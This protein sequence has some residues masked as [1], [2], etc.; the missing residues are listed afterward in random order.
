M[1]DDT[2]HH[3]GHA[4][5][6]PARRKAGASSH[7]ATAGAKKASTGKKGATRKSAAHKGGAGEA[8]TT[9]TKTVKRTAEH[10]AT[11]AKKAASDRKA[12]NWA[13]AGLG[14]GSAALAAAV[15][16]ASRMRKGAQPSPTSTTREPE[17]S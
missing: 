13:A 8:V 11:A 12:R 4:S 16:Y 5:A 1:S 10:A 2:E 17:E 14:V 15:L 6:K 3:E 9:A 7:S